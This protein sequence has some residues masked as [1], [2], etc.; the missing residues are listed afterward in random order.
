MSSI[1][2]FSITAATMSSV[3]KPFE[4]LPASVLPMNYKLTL[5]PNLTEF[6][7]T[8]EEVIDVEVKQE[9][10][11]VIINCLDINVTSASF[12]LGEQSY[13][14]S[15]ICHH[16]EDETVEI[17]FASPLPLGQG[18]LCLDFTGE[19]N[20]KLKGFY[21]CKYS[22]E[23]GSE[24]FCAVTHFEPTGA[25]RAFPCWDEPA[26][27]ATFDITLIVPKDRVALS[28]MNVKEEKDHTED[29]SL[30]VVKYARTPVMSTYL[31]AFV[32]GEFDFVEGK[33]ANGVIIRVYTPKGK[34]VQG[35]FALEVAKKC[36]PFYKE[37]FGIGYL[38]PKLDLIAIQDFVIGAMENWGLVT[39]R[40][41]CLLI[42]PSD[43][44]SA[45]KQYVALV[46]GHELAHM[47][48]GNL[49]TVEWWTHLWLK[50]G[51]ASWIEY[52]LVDHCFP[53]FDVWTQFVSTDFA[54]ALKLDALNNSHPI[55]VPVGH[56][57]EIDEIFDTISYNKGASVIRM[58]HQ[59]VGN[60][61]FRKG[62]NHYL[63][64]FEYNAAS[65]G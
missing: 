44:S 8:G 4:R 28:N 64:T 48:F 46:V 26:I 58:L 18:E 59:Y 23:D 22:G 30:K 45:A 20:K 65:T 29:T 15:S 47:W 1:T 38:L 54:S 62:L 19:L 16:F 12:S 50:E 21:R 56:P 49:V 51:F 61:D 60:Q 31:V 5:Q 32:V 36:L 24:K 25:R 7:F 43:S 11:K 57:G 55:E 35:Q 3:K 6:T 14:S 41:T 13:P 52:L 34:A 40:E 9:T 33:D 17:S 42:D 63:K 53:E 10:D 27:R 2:R 37:Y 39:Y